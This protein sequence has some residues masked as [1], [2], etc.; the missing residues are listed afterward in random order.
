M[1][2]NRKTIIGLTIATLVLALLAPSARSAILPLLVVLACPIGML[3]MMRGMAGSRSEPPAGG[4]SP[5]DAEH[6]RPSVDPKDAEVARLRAEVEQL[7]AERHS[8]PGAGGSGSD[9]AA[10]TEV[11]RR[12]GEDRAR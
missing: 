2:W 4:R 10:D 12:P 3:V 8:V 11:S 9:P 1:C 6:P 5:V 7:R